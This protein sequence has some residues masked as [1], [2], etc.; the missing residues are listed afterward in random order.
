MGPEMSMNNLNMTSSPSSSTLA[1]PKLHDDGSNWAD[2]YPR[3]QN[4]MGAKGLWRHMEG[5]ATALVPF[6]LSDGVPM[7]ADG[8]TKAT[9]DQIELKE[10]K[11]LEFEK[12]KYLAGH[13]L[14]STTSLCL[15]TKIKSLLTAEDMWKAVKD[16]ATSKSTLFILDAKDQL[17]SLKL[18]ENNNP[19]AHLAKLTNNFQLVLECHDNLIKMGSV[20]S[21][22][23]FTII[24]MSPLP[25]SYQ[26]TLQ[27]ITANK[28]A[29]KLSGIWSSAMKADD[30]ISFI[31]EEA[32]HRVINDECTKSAESTLAAHMK[33]TS[34]SKG[35][36]KDKN[37]SKL[38]VTCENC[39]RLG[40]SITDCYSKEGGKEGQGRWGKNKT[41]GKQS[42]TMA[43]IA[44][45]DQ[46]DDL[47]AFTCMSDYLAVA[48]MLNVPRSKLGTCID[49]G[50]SRHY[51]P[52][53]SKFMDYKSIECKITTANGRT[54]KTAGM[55]NLHIELP[56]GSG[57]TKTILKN[58]IHTPEMVFTLISISRLDRVGV[59]VTGSWA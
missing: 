2:Y 42:E 27:T 11:I 10:L 16:D 33:K 46:K 25:A 3:L 38:D 48:K 41:K 29:G 28:Q 34:K 17:S 37:Q 7:L 39:N 14:M 55:G 22:T 23:R 13:I 43:V 45:D 30:L 49:S 4:V 1:V 6:I 52:D 40:H 20:M 19:K 51:C 53:Q 32:Q 56:N 5:T 57:K 18:A 54:L 36:K 44:D 59:R 26:P 8:K 50:A 15:S 47:F 35:K 9:E 31:F 58:A 21:K 12:R 24:I